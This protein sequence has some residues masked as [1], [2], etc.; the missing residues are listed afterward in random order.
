MA[1]VKGVC[2]RV[3]PNFFNLFESKRK[4]YE[5]RFKVNISQVQTS[6]L[7][8]KELIKRMNPKIKINSSKRYYPKK[9]KQRFP[10]G[11]MI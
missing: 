2:I 6:E 3:H 5:S 10:N 11:F 9:V 1:K 8:S 4:N 7:I